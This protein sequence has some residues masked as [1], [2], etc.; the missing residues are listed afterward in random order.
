MALDL[1]FTVIKQY[2]IIVYMLYTL[3]SAANKLITYFI[4]ILFIM[5]KVNNIITK[6]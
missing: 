6:S 4:N 5:C 2:I 1:L 3:I